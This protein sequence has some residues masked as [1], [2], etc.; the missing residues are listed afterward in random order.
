[1][2]TVALFVGG[3]KEEEDAASGS[4]LSA[5]SFFG[6]RRRMMPLPELAASVMDLQA[7]CSSSMALLSPSHRRI[8][9]LQRMETRGGGGVRGGHAPCGVLRGSR[10]WRFDEGGSRKDQTPWT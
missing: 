1:M 9:S 7:R 10:F 8:V 6:G 3:R 5:A 4:S 2:H